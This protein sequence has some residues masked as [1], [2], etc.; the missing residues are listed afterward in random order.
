MFSVIGGRISEGM[1]PTARQR[2]LQHYYEMKFHKGWEYTVEAPTAR[3]LVQSIGRLIRN[4]NDRG[5][6]VILDWR[7][8]RFRKYLDGLRESKDLIK[9]IKRFIEN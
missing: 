4:E 2:G 1:K 9:D 6:A 8:K 5:I 3:K 7:A